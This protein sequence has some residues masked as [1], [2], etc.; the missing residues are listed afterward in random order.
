MSTTITDP[1]PNAPSIDP[2]APTPDPAP[3]PAPEPASADPPA[4]EPEPPQT[5]DEKAKARDEEG[6]RVAAVRARLGAAER[7]RDRLAAEVQFWRAQGQQPPRPGQPPTPEQQQVQLR[8]QI[9]AEESARLRGEMFHAEGSNQFPDWK[10]RCDDLV[11]MGADSGFAQLLVEMPGG[12]RV[13][14]ALAA[15]PQEVEK[16]AAIRSERGR[17]VAL[18]KYAATLEAAGNGNGTARAPVAPVTRAPA[19]VR[20]VTGRANPVFNEYTASAQQLADHY[21]Q[22]A[23]D[24]QKRH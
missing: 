7:E 1:K 11:A 16:I 8:E 14:A 10:Q 15:D 12:V 21:F 9:R 20:P 13:A 17:A 2:P 22:Q 23:L 4:P 18:G 24:R 3:P 6:R 5:E 19:P